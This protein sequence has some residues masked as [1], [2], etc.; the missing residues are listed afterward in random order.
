MGTVLDAADGFV[1][2]GGRSERFGADKFLHVVNGRSMGQRAIDALQSLRSVTVVGPPRGSVSGASWWMGTREGEGPL[3]AIVDVLERTETGVAVVLGCDTPAV[4]GLVVD[5]LLRAL[6]PRDAAAFADDGRTHW[7]V[8]AWRADL[9]AVPLRSA[10][11]LGE[12]SV[13]RAVS[14]LAISRVAT[15]STLLLN[16]NRGADV[17]A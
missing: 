12:R 5:R 11:E 3:G 10:W 7:L 6:R 16:A 9:A 4:D 14:G 2:A 17:G 15:P 1:L 8:G 13:H